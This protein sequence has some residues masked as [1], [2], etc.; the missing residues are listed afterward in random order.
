MV[1]QNGNNRDAALC[2]LSAPVIYL[3]YAAF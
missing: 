2:S 1:G 3:R